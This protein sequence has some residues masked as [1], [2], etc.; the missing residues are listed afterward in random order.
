MVAVPDDEKSLRIIMFTGFDRIHERDVYPDR[1]KTETDKRTDGRTD[2][3]RQHRPRLCIA[4]H[5]KNNDE[6]SGRHH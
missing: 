1:Q 5:C 6:S 3:A 4:S 2:T